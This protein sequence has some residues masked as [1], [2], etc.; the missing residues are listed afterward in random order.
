ML[1]FKVSIIARVAR[2]TSVHS[3]SGR[4]VD[5]SRWRLVFSLNMYVAAGFSRF[6]VFARVHRNWL[7]CILC[8]R[9]GTLWREE[10]TACCAH[11]CFSCSSRTCWKVGFSSVIFARRKRPADTVARQL[12]RCVTHFFVYR[13]DVKVRHTRSNGETRLSPP[14]KA[15]HRLKQWLS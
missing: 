15:W 5:S 8:L 2:R 14:R 11:C 3:R 1:H 7:L 9:R 12:G 10:I 13:I 6:L 4:A